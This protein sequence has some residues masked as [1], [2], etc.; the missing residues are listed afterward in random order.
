M[1]KKCEI[2]E[3]EFDA[4]G[5]DICCSKKCAEE[6]KE[7]KDKIYRKKYIIITA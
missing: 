7:G 6:N 3:Q 4:Q 2:C 1:I 5:S